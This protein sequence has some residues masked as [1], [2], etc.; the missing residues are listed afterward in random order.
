MKNNKTQSKLSLNKSTIAKL[1][2]SKSLEGGDVLCS[3]GTGALT[4]ATK[5]AGCL[6]VEPQYTMLCASM[7]CTLIRC[8][9]TLYQCPDNGIG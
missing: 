7:F 1:T 4:L 8:P 5:L 3:I 9:G 6:T 2:N